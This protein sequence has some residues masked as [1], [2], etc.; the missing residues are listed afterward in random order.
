MT[1]KKIQSDVNKWTNQFE[2]QYWQPHEILA[3]LVEETGEVAREINHLYGPKKKKANEKE[4]DLGDEIA[5][6]IFTLCC[7][8]NSKDIDLD[9]SWQRIMDKC[10]IRDNDRYNKKE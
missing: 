8:A 3:R 1:L 10:Y 7:L 6:V 2:P 9:K 4:Q 5:D